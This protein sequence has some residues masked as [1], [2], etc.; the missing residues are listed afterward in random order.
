MSNK[1]KHL[2]KISHNSGAKKDFKNKD[3]RS[4]LKVLVEVCRR[5]AFVA[6]SHK[7]AT[8]TCKNSGNAGLRDPCPPSVIDDMPRHSRASLLHAVAALTAPLLTAVAYANGL[9]HGVWPAFAATLLAGLL[10]V[11]VA[12]AGR[13]AVAAFVA[14][15]A[16][17]LALGIS[18]V[19]G[20]GRLPVGLAS[21]HVGKAIGGLAA[22]AM[23]PSA[24]SWNRH[25]TLIAV[26]CVAGVP[27]IA[28]VVGY[29]H[30]AP[31]APAVVL[32]FATA[33]LFSTIA[34]EWFFRRWVQQPLQRFGTVVAVVGSAVL[35]GMVH[36][37]SGWTF[38]VLAGVAGLGYAGAYHASGRSM[39]AAVVVH[40]AL[41][42]TR[43][44][45]FGG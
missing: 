24:W 44:A 5:A 25:C 11:S 32:A 43:K 36:A 20:Y 37:P 6:S 14:A 9:A 31:A 3:L 39:W 22:A 10:Y 19:P 8:R 26:A 30:W 16:V 38:M 42:V 33:N 17:L 41:N 12:W 21:I 2:Q 18:A 27:A 7:S 28:W 1:I 29:V 13:T 34:E 4:G 23:L 35:F 45:L 15:G 40:L